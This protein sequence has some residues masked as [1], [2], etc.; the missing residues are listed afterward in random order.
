MNKSKLIK[1]AAIG[2]GAYLLY[3]HVFKKSAPVAVAPAPVAVAPAPIHP[4]TAA[5]MQ[6]MGCVGCLGNPVQ[7]V[8][9]ELETM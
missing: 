6:G 1:Y 4:A 8:S 3:E 7:T 2:V 5:A 9:A